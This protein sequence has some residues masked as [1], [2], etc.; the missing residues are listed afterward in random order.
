MC[1][2]QVVYKKVRYTGEVLNLDMRKST[3]N[4]TRYEL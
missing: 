4:K 3:G 2:V 1:E